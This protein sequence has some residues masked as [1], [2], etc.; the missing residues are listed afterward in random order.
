MQRTVK[1]EIETAV[2]K[3]KMTLFTVRLFVA[4]CCHKWTHQ[5]RKHRSRLMNFESSLHRSQNKITSGF[6]FANSD[7][8][9]AACH[10]ASHLCHIELGDP[11]NVGIRRSNHDHCFRNQANSYK[12]LEFYLR[13]AASVVIH[14]RPFQLSLSLLISQCFISFCITVLLSFSRV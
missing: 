3:L 1:S 8:G 2:V 7:S 14:A 4:R 6:M 10:A 11:K 13:I 5:P 9:L 12:L